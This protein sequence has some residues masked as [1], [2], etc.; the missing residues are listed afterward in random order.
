MTNDKSPMTN[1]FAGHPGSIAS[2]RLGTPVS[3]KTQET[4]AQA[5]SAPT[6]SSRWN[7]VKNRTFFGGE[8]GKG[9]TQA[10]CQTVLAGGTNLGLPC[11]LLIDP[12]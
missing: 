7:V 2:P 9:V 1:L 11:D 3:G 10:M 5:P 8:K 12:R 4:L 6:L